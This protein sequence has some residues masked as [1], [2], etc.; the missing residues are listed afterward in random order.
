MYVYFTG[1]FILSSMAG[2]TI[3]NV[4]KWNGSSDLNVVA[5][6][7]AKYGLIHLLLMYVLCIMSMQ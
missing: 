3:V 1:L 7:V 2:R 4:Y 5:E 6:G